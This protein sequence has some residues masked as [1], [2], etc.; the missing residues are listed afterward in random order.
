LNDELKQVKTEAETQSN[1]MARVIENIEELLGHGG[2]EQFL[3]TVLR[4]LDAVQE[5]YRIL[6]QAYVQLLERS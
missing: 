4:Q 2:P 5:E 6:Y 3:T 1:A